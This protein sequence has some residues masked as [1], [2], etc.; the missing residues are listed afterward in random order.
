M[1]ALLGW[2]LR[3][4]S[5]LMQPLYEYSFT[6]YTNLK[7]VLYT[8]LSDKHRNSSWFKS[9]TMTYI[10]WSAAQF[11]TLVQLAVFKTQCCLMCLWSPWGSY[12]VVLNPMWLLILY[13]LSI[14]SN[15]EIQSLSAMTTRQ[16]YLSL[17]WELIS[18][19]HITNCPAFSFTKGESLVLQHWLALIVQT[20]RLIKNC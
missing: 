8:S 10:I 9:L 1:Y 17:P 2:L 7:I 14:L 4:T 13:L 3:Q 12:L 11:L 19:P 5:Y 18:F 20:K 16:Q 15:F 6:S